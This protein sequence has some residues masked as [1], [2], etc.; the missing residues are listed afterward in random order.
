MLHQRRMQCS[1]CSVGGATQRTCYLAN[2]CCKGTVSIWCTK[3]GWY[4]AI[5]LP[6]TCV[7]QHGA[8]PWVLPASHQRSTRLRALRRHIEV[9]KEGATLDEPVQIWRVDVIGIM[10]PDVIPSLVIC[11]DDNEVWLLASWQGWD[12]HLPWSH[13]CWISCSKQC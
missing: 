13:Y 7:H 10:Q 5:L 11:Q 2:T 12:G 1:C 9:G 3:D 8:G 4:V 6:R